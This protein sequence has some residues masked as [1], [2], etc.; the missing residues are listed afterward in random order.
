MEN[1]RNKLIYIMWVPKVAA[2]A[3]SAAPHTHYTTTGRM[4]SWG[5]TPMRAWTVGSEDRIECPHTRASPEVGLKR[6]AIMLM[7]VV[8]PA[9]LWPSS[10]KHL[11]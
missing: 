2:S 8:L 10:P 9:P 4:L 11:G 3:E 7:H 1:G 5:Q 6:P